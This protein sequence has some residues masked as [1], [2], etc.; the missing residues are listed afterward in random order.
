MATIDGFRHNLLGANNHSMVFDNCAS[1][2]ESGAQNCDRCRKSLQLR[3]LSW[4][5][6]QGEGADH[7]APPRALRPRVRALLEGARLAR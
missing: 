5:I 2:Q 6:I 3:D 4:Q 1:C 7:S